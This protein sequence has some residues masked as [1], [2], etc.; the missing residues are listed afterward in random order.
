[1][2]N[3]KIEFLR[4]IF[5]I[6]IVLFHCGKDFLPHV[7]FSKGVHISLFA[8]GAVGVEF[9]F[10]LSGLLMAR[11]AYKNIAKPASGEA[12]FKEHTAFMSRKYMSIFPVHCIGFVFAFISSFLLSAYR[13]SKIAWYFLDSIP[14]LFLVQ[15]SGLRYRDPN[16]IEWYI[17]CML[18]VMAVLY[19]V[20]R[21]SYYGFTRYAAPVLSLMIIGWIIQTT[22]GL[23]GVM[24]WSGLCYKSLLRAFADISLGATAYELSA[25]LGKTTFSKSRKVFLTVLEWLIYTAVIAFALFN[26]PTKYEGLIPFLLLPALALSFSGKTGFPERWNHQWIFFL[27]K[28]SLP[29]YVSQR[30]AIYL[31]HYFFSSFSPWQ[32]V[33]VAFEL[34]IIVSL[35]VYALSVLCKKIKVRAHN[36]EKSV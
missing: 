34:T 27:G 8:H 21:K 18:I 10:M 5:S 15:M 22:G 28:L 17:S 4:F 3:G 1:M 9:F 36:P 6:V 35:I 2:K 23:T 11:T 19:P 24:E 20:L 13:G 31:T 12:L 7:F 32:S 33:W 29:I 14:N 30:S 16:N 26:L 25:V